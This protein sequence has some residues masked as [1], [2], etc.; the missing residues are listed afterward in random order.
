MSE[1]LNAIQKNSE[2]QENITENEWEK[3]ID[4]KESI[5]SSIENSELKKEFKTKYKQLDTFLK[6][7]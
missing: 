6:Q 1:F 5:I 2:A 7:E 3:I 4:G